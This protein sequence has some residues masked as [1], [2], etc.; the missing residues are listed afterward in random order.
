MIELKIEFT[1]KKYEDSSFQNQYEDVE[2]EQ[3]IEN[4]K[5]EVTRFQCKIKNSVDEE[6]YEKIENNKN[7]DYYLDR[8]TK[9]KENVNVNE[10]LNLVIM[11]RNEI[12]NNVQVCRKEIMIVK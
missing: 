4:L 2:N 1:I 11:L 10:T 3:I 5:K 8:D 7:D 12:M 9:L 6:H